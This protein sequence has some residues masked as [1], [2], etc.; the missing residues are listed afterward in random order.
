MTKIKNFFKSIT[1]SKK[2]IF[3]LALSVCVVVL[4]I[5]G[6][7]IAYFTDTAKITN[8]FTSG[9]VT[10]ELSEAKVTVGANGHLVKDGTE[11]ITGTAD[12]VENKTFEASALFPGQQIYKDPTIK[13]TG[14]NSAYLGAVI[15][16]TTNAGF[17]TLYA[18]K[19][20]IKTLF[21]H[22][23]PSGANVTVKSVTNGY[24][25][26]VVYTGTYAKDSE[27]VIFDGVQIPTTWKNEDMTNVE[28]FKIVVEAYAVQIDGFDDATEALQAAFPTVFN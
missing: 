18:N 19:D 20:D 4:S 15:T 23:A 28:G 24:A 1:N 8:T 13:N 2:K 27:V 26:Y 3:A 12:G 16:V 10:I 5:A 6:S 14:K 17:G 25:I 9:N 22:L 7:S 21:T 11:R